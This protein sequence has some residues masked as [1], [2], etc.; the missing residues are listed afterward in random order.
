MDECSGNRTAS[1][2][3]VNVLLGDPDALQR[4]AARATRMPD[5]CGIKPRRLSICARSTGRG[6]GRA[7][8][9]CDAQ[10]VAVQR[11]ELAGVDQRR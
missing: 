7:L 2:D 8:L 1:D 5:S 6:R 9:A 10:Q 3:S 4:S 11:R